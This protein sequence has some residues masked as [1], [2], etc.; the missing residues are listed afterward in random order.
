MIE[1]KKGTWPY[2]VQFSENS[3]A[4]RKKLFFNCLFGQ[5][6]RTFPYLNSLRICYFYNC[7]NVSCKT[8]VACAAL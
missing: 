6:Y 7:K 5:F 3:L 2:K 8:K 4:G 1:K